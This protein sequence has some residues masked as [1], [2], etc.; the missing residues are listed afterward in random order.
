MRTSVSMVAGAL[1]IL[2]LSAPLVA[3]KPICTD[4][5]L[6]AKLQP[7]ID[8]QNNAQGVCGTGKAAKAIADASLSAIKG[9][10]PTSDI[11][12][13]RAQLQQMRESAEEQ[14]A[15]SCSN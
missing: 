14:I 10:T 9:C 12:A 4:E 5:A 15:G 1:T 2:L 3:A 13:L 8:A 11:L 7:L 6:Q